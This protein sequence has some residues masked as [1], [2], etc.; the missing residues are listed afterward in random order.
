M[1]VSGGLKYEVLLRI[2]FQS[3]EVEE[4]NP[5]FIETKLIPEVVND[6][7]DINNLIRIFDSDYNP[8]FNLI[9]ERVFYNYKRR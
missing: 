8:I 6:P 4:Q 3:P 1:F 7:Q 2:L 5:F 9:A